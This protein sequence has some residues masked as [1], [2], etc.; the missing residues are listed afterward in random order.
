M[1][2]GNCNTATVQ[3]IIGFVTVWV[4]SWELT[5]TMRRVGGM[6]EAEG[7]VE[8]REWGVVEVDSGVV[9]FSWKNGR[10]IREPQSG[11]RTFAAW[12]KMKRGGSDA[13]V[14]TAAK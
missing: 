2:L 11:R 5:V 1:P 14:I 12:L 10:M 13:E 8:P 9:I 4:D 6:W 7:D 3:Q